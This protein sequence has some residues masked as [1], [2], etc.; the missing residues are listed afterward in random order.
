[1]KTKATTAALIL[2]AATCLAS[3][4]AQANTVYWKLSNVAFSDGGTAS[5]TFF[6]DAATNLYSDVNVTTTLGTVMAGGT[7][8]S[9]VFGWRS[10][11]LLD[12]D[13]GLLA[14]VFGSPLTDAGTPVSV[15]SAAEFDLSDG[16]SISWRTARS[17]SL[18]D[19]APPNAVP[20]PGTLALLAMGLAGIALARWRTRAA[21]RVAAGRR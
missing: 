14:L 3:L 16:S 9:P 10:A 6:Y 15:V 13:F 11:L 7:Y 20:E 21:V 2:A 5:G 12:N 18:V 4:P 8:R 19:P 1:M 17:G